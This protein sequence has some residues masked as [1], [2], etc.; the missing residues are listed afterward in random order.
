MNRVD[1]VQVALGARSYDILVGAGLLEQAGERLAP[2]LRQPRVVVVTD[3]NV[4]PLY[5]AALEASLSGA[6]IESANIV[7][8][9]GEET[10]NFDVIQR[11]VTRLL[12]AR[13]E[14]KTTVIAL[15]G[16]VI[17]D[18]TGFAASIALRGVDFVQAPTT[19]L[20][21]VDSSVG[22]KTGIN[23]PHG[24]NL[25]GSF[26]QPRLVLADIAT[27]NTLP[28]R[29]LLAGYAE[30]VKYALIGDPDFFGWLEKNGPA[31]CEGDDILRQQAVGR[32]CRAKAEIVADDEREAGRRSLLNLGHTF[33]HALEAETGYGEVLIHGE[34]VAIGMI[35]AFELSERLGLC[36]PEDCVRLR[37]HFD[38]MGLPTR[39]GDIAGRGRTPEA[40]LDHMRQDKKLQDGKIAFVLTRGIGKAFLTTDVALPD[41]ETLLQD[42]LAA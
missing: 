11:I 5:L 21:Q 2:I 36:P 23:T 14:R 26:Y 8:P 33:G 15:G 20:S 18:L 37:A 39:I 1:R 41:L 27:L 22:G 25:V 12:D 29:E 30:T 34:A 10:K 31:L 40:L 4:A 32:C 16:G 19:L 9:H 24:K 38:A 6:G 13:I 35:M 28:R 7:L 42:S 3:D 17:G